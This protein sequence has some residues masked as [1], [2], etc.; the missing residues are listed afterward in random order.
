MQVELSNLH[1]ELGLTCIMVTH[2]QQEA[3]SLSDRIAI[4]NQGKIEQ[5]GKPAQIYERPRTP[6]V[7][8]FIGDTNLFEGEIVG[9][10]NE[11]VAILTKAGIKII[12][13]RR[14]D[15]T[16]VI[17]KP[18]LISVR[19]EK[20]QLSLYKPSIQNNCFEGR[21][22]NTM[23]M[24]THINYMVELNQCL[25]VNI[26][27]PNTEGILPDSDIPIYAWWSETDCLALQN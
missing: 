25:R 13:S 6:F 27:Q 3:L 21:L 16:L 26:R 22:I 9:A 12:V 15:T 5:I 19:P 7:A 18:V 23:Y 8:D 4:M 20:I 17:S 2:D 10:N 24:G 1:R 14:E 11:E